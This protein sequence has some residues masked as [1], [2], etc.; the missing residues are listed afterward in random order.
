MSKRTYHIR[1]RCFFGK[2]T[3]N[4]TDHNMVMEL[5]KI[6]KWIEAYAYTHPGVQSITAKVWPQDKEAGA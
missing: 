5:R 2:N 1:F 4:Y 6:G 3:G